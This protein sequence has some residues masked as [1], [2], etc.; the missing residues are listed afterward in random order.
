MRCWVLNCNEET[1]MRWSSNGLNFFAKI[2]SQEIASQNTHPGL[3]QSWV[4]S[5][6]QTV[7]CSGRHGQSRTMDVITRQSVIRN[8]S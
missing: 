4:L 6:Y 2:R 3:R 5:D 1:R 7:F 8:G